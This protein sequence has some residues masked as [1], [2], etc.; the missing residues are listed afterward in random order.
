MEY[1]DPG[2][3]FVIQGFF[4]HS[5]ALGRASGIGC[6]ISQRKKT[7]EVLNPVLSSGRGEE[8]AV[9]AYFNTSKGSLNKRSPVSILY[10]THPRD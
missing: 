3:S 7:Q 5:S 8:D 9:R 6:R 10:K 1:S 2:V 4:Q